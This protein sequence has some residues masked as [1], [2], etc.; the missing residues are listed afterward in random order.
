MEL[1]II[2]GVILLSA[3]IF[4]GALFIPESTTQNT[5][6]M[7]WQID[8]IDNTTRVFNLTLGKSTLSE[9]E[10]ILLGDAE[11]SL[12]RSQE[13]AHSVEAYFDKVMLGGLSA[14]IVLVMDISEPELGAIYS[15]G[16]RISKLGSGGNKV[17]IATEDLHRVRSSAIAGITYLPAINLNADQL[18]SRFGQPLKRIK[19]PD[20]NTEHWLYPEIG[21]DVTLNEQGKDI[22][23]YIE[24]A[25]FSKISEPL[26]KLQ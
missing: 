26:E 24:P 15:R 17:S 10:N 3:A 11:V 16:V 12:F 5:Q 7:P 13:N 22:L 6:G 2:G 21:L 9:A 8:K 14:K 18:I 20:N 19:E 4:L 25:K 1:K 23:Q